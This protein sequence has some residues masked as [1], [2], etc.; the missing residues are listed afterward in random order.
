MGRKCLFLWVLNSMDKK[1]LIGELLGTFLLVFIGC[2][3]VAAAVLKGWLDL[4]GVAI[5]FGSG[6][7]LGIL[8]SKK[9]CGSHLNPA[10]TLSLFISGNAKSK[11]LLPAIMGQCLG[12]FLGGL[13]VFYLWES[14]ILEFETALGI[15]K[16]DKGSEASAMIFGEFFPNPTF[17]NVTCSQL[18][19]CFIEGLGTFILMTIIYLLGRM[20]K[21]SEWVNPFLIGLTVTGLIIFLAPYTQGGFNPA[22]D[23]FPRIVAYL[24]GWKMN[25]FPE[26]SYS[27]FT[28]YILSPIIG[29]C[30]SGLIFRKK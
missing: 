28:V 9:W 6:V 2:S 25:A 21:K 26:Q 14:Q 30:A 24:H 12:A 19:G 27:F 10:V 13:A 22:R 23:F 15:S 5:V 8:A 17:P 29:A 18:F 11:E 4:Y 3:S 16:M 20:P 1:L 7:T